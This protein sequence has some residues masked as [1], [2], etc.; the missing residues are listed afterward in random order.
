VKIKVNISTFTTKVIILVTNSQSIFFKRRKIS[1]NSKLKVFLFTVCFILIATIVSAAPF[2][3]FHVGHTSKYSKTDSAATPNQWVVTME[4]V[5]TATP[6]GACT[7]AQ[8]YQIKEC[9]YDGDDAGC[10]S[11]EYMYLA[12]TENAGYRCV[13]GVEYKFFQTGDGGTTWDHAAEGGGTRYYEVTGKW[14]H[15][16]LYIIR[17]YTVDGGGITQPACINFFM[18]G[19]GM[20]KEVDLWA[21]NAPTKSVRQ[22]YAGY[23]VFAAWNGQGVFSYDYDGNTTWSRLNAATPA[24]MVA[25]GPFLYAAWTGQGLF[26]YDGSVW[27]RINTAVPDN[28]WAA[29]S[30]LYATWAGQG[31]FKWESSTGAWTRLNA[32]V[33][34]N[35][36]PAGSGSVIYV[37]W[38]GQGIF[39]YDGTTWTR[40][41]ATVPSLWVR[42]N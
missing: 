24:K 36:A 16:D 6:G 39:K 29:G 19:F 1:M 26:I 28:M 2:W 37:T 20:I 35:V 22:G 30:R 31:F 21:A 5:G 13:G 4:V 23:G 34:L 7:S 15:G 18:R 33:P 25:S 38:T 3:Q 42:G 12:V 14:N 9:N 10:A 27:T 40:I 8:Y 17:S 11:P 32:T 41:N